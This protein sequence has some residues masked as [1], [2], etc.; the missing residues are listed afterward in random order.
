MRR[1][2]IVNCSNNWKEFDAEFAQK[3]LEKTKTGSIDFVKDTDRLTNWG[4]YHCHWEVFLV[5]DYWKDWQKK[6]NFLQT[7]E[8]VNFYT[9]RLRL[10]MKFITDHTRK[11]TNFIEGARPWDPINTPKLIEQEL[12]KLEEISEEEFQRTN[13]WNS[14]VEWKEMSAEELKNSFFK[15]KIETLF[16]REASEKITKPVNY[17]SLNQEQLEE[18]VNKLNSLIS[19]VKSEQDLNQ[20]Q[21][22]LVIQGL[23]NQLNQVQSIISRNNSNNNEPW[24]ILSIVGI[25]LAVAIFLSA[26]L[27]VVYKV[28]KNKTRK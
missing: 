14:G 23:E 12:R 13:K 21:T 16:G 18:E 8:E 27:I 22:K 28:R 20:F 7:I 4:I 5:S 19:K 17:N 6:I 1:F 3:V 26:G 9:K 24:P 25:V 2:L 15:E 10:I 11:N